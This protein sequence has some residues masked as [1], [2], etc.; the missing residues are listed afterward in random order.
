MEI[1]FRKCIFNND[2]MKVILIKVMKAKMT[3]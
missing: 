3:Y 1:N 2:F